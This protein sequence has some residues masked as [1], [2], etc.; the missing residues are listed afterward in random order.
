MYNARGGNR[1]NNC[2]QCFVHSFVSFE[3]LPLVEFQLDE[4]ITDKE[5]EMLI[6]SSTESASFD[7]V[8]DK[9]DK[10][11][12]SLKSSSMDEKSAD[13][14]KEKESDDQKQ[15][16]SSVV[17]AISQMKDFTEILML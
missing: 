6:Q 10:P 15:R 4:G 11:K 17:S 2:G 12:M 3:I 7:A 14:T 8:E 9:S 16:S 1:C 5:A 13:K